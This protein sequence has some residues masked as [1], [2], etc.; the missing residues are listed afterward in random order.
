MP[1]SQIT[2]KNKTTGNNVPVTLSKFAPSDAEANTFVY[3]AKVEDFWLG[4]YEGDQIE[5]TYTHAIA[6]APQ[7][8]WFYSWEGGSSSDFGTGQTAEFT[9]PKVSSDGKTLTVICDSKSYA[10]VGQSA[11]SKFYKIHFNNV[12]KGKRFD[13][14]YSSTTCE[15]R[16]VY[17]HYDEVRDYLT[18]APYVTVTNAFSGVTVFSGYMDN[19]GVI[20]FNAGGKNGTVIVNVTV[21]GVALPA[22]RTY[23]W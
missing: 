11:P 23:I 22:E 12:H 1:V 14:L 10:I 7:L 16:V 6:E 13:C 21:N 15:F 8:A 2:V 17:N 4:V 5:V 9:V 18:K 20:T 3:Q 19:N